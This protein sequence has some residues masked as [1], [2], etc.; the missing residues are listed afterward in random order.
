MKVRAMEKFGRNLGLVLRHGH[1]LLRPNVI[2]VGEA[3]SKSADLQNSA[4]QN[5]EASTLGLN[6]A[7]NKP[8]AAENTFPICT[9]AG[10]LRL[11]S[12]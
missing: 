8:G 10:A 12:G 6:T 4:V 1:M 2:A 11:V 7:A 9:G 3:I 5:V